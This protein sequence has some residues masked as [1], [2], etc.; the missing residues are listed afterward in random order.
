M[1]ERLIYEGKAT[2]EDL[3]TLNQFGFEFVVEDGKIT[4]IYRNRCGER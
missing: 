3:Y 4:K 1:E 2:L